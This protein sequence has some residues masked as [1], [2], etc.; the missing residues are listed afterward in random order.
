M[1]IH[2]PVPWISL[3]LIFPFFFPSQALISPQNKLTLPMSLYMYSH[4]LFL[5]F[6]HKV[7]GQIERSDFALFLEVLLGL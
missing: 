2:M 5:L 4:L 3:S 7:D 6:L 1:F